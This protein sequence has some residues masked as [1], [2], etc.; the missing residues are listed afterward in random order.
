[1]I[2]AQVFLSTSAARTWGDMEISRGVDDLR[3]YSETG[4][5]TGPGAAK[6]HAPEEIAERLGGMAVKSLSELIRKSGVETTTVGYEDSPRKGGKKRRI[7]GM[8]DPQLEALL[9]LWKPRG[10][11]ST[12]A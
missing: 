6:L 7:W 11:K 12:Q 8:T 4:S 3:D 10:T 1:M 9:R 2:D 5:V